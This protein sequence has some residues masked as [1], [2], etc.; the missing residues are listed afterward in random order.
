MIGKMIYGSDGPQFPGY[1]KSHLQAFVAGMQEADYTAEEIEQILSGN[2]L[3]VFKL[4]PVQ[5][6]DTK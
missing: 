1:V 5:L 2:F 3:R 6:G 4:P